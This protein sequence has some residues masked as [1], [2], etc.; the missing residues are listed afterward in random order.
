[1]AIVPATICAPRSPTIHEKSRHNIHDDDSRLPAAGGDA[2]PAEDDWVDGEFKVAGGGV[3]SM[4][5]PEYWGKK[6]ERNAN[7]TITDLK[8]GPY[9][10]RSKPVFMV[11]V[12]HD[13]DWHPD[14]GPG[15]PRDH[16]G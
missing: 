4:S 5:Y 13:S 6:P 1:M 11:R 10:P 8:F 16:Q 3:L 12:N 15:H 14:R 9:G 2:A 7:E